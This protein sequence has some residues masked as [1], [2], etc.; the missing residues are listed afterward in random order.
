M[1]LELHLFDFDG[2]L[3]RSPFPPEGFTGNPDDWYEDPISLDP[4]CVPRRPGG[5]WFSPVISQ[6]KAS[7]ADPGVFVAIA[8]GRKRLFRKR[9]LEIFSAGGIKPD[10]FA[11]NPG[12]RTV[13]FKLDVIRALV[14]ANPSIQRVQAWD[15]RHNHLKSFQ[16]AVEKWGLEFIGH[17]IRRFERPPECTIEYVLENSE[18]SRVARRAVVREVME[19]P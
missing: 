7:V 18:L 13:T 11:T 5:S 9:L 6:F 14:R 16:G 17:P 4:P 2:T 1:I 15:D 12:T 10:F 3:F 8:T 19:S